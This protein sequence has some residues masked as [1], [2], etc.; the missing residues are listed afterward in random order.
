MRHAASVHGVPGRCRR[1][2]SVQPRSPQFPPPTPSH[3]ASQRP[4]GLG[5]PPRPDILALFP[6][7]LRAGFVDSMDAEEGAAGAE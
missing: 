4:A 3:E 6:R 2:T 7:L 1:A 5:V